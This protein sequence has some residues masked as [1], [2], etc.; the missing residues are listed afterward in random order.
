[1][2][3]STSVAEGI[4]RLIGLANNC[5]LTPQGCA[6][7][8]ANAATIIPYCHLQGLPAHPHPHPRPGDRTEPA[9]ETTLHCA[10]LLSV[11]LHTHTLLPAEGDNKSWPS[12][13]HS[14]KPL[15]NKPQPLAE[16]ESQFD[17]R[18]PSY[19][20][21]FVAS[22][23]CC[24]ASSKSYDVCRRAFSPQAHGSFQPSAPIPLLFYFLTLCLRIC[25]RFFRSYSAT[26]CRTTTHVFWSS[27][28]AQRFWPC[29]CR[30]PNAAPDLEV[31]SY[32]W[33]AD[34]P[35]TSLGPD[36]SNISLNLDIER[37]GFCP[38]FSCYLMSVLTDTV[39]LDIPRPAEP[40]NN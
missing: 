5:D 24:P 38:H 29:L 10:P 23:L 11:Y 30:I 15:C 40:P 34:K 26:P 31:R 16:D 28:K 3:A 36:P 21:V 39:C 2:T 13:T 37:Y 32:N 33:P 19:R 14:S 9:K 1:V 7:V 17:L 27:V 18:A 12:S 6:G 25:P 4:N 8:C 20:R 35:C 22:H